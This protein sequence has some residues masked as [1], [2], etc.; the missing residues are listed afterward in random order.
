MA[1][2][3]GAASG[4]GQ[5]TAELLAEHGARVVGLDLAGAVTARPWGRGIVADV[6]DEGQVVAAV[7]DVVA[8]EGRLDILVNNAGLAR[9]APVQQVR[10]ADADLM[11]RVNARGP[12]LLCREAFR[13]MAAQGGGEIVNV[14]STAGLRGEP[15][16]SVYC[17]TKF[18]LRG[19]TEAIAE[20]GRLCNVRVHAIFPGGV[21]TAFWSTASATPLTGEQREGFMQP[22]DVARAI[23]AAL[24]T[25]ARVQAQSLVLRAAGDADR[26]H[27][28]RRMA[29]FDVPAAAADA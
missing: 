13:A 9:H 19:F 18:A 11:W 28:R 6:A 3:T 2:V 17:A 7:R 16:E 8:G 26:E 21:D 1:L 22:G 5:A 4:I 27:I 24:C 23:V 15:G 25:P 10:A 20:E 12:I 14:V 29:R